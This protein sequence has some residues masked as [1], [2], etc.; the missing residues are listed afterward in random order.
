MRIFAWEVQLILVAKAANAPASFE[1][2][3][4]MHANLWKSFYKAS[5]YSEARCRYSLTG[6][7]VMQYALFAVFT[8]GCRAFAL[9]TE[10]LFSL[11]VIV[12]VG[13]DTKVRVVG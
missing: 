11:A 1:T 6:T 5:R 12:V 3:F 4:S 8:R 9:R 13:M 7:R 2:H 10:S